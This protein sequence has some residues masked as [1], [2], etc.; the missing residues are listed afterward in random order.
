MDLVDAD[1]MSHFVTKISKLPKFSSENIKEMSVKDL[2]MLS[3]E[4][5]LR[6]PNGGC[7][8]KRFWIFCISFGYRATKYVDIQFLGNARQS[9]TG[10]S[11]RNELSV[12]IEQLCFVRSI[13][14]FWK[15][16]QSWL[17]CFNRFPNL[18]YCIFYIFN[19]IICCFQ[20]NQ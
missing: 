3:D 14:K 10:W 17:M 6:R 16:N 7:V 5:A 8:V 2:S 4:L 18:G 20:L 1:R 13:K 11:I 12:F 9:G 15:G 19:F